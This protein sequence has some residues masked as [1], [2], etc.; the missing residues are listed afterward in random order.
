MFFY[1]YNRCYYDL[2]LILPSGVPYENKTEK[3]VHDPMPK[4]ANGSTDENLHNC[5]R[6]C[7]RGT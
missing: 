2:A 3:I 1:F 4:N 6:Y 5:R 7:A